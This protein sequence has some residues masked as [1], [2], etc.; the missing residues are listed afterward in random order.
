MQNQMDSPER[1]AAA[2]DQLRE[3]RYPDHAGLIECSYGDLPGFS[4]RNK[5]VYW[6]GHRATRLDD[7]ETWSKFLESEILDLQ[8]AI[9]N[10]S[11]ERS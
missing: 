8:T 1:I 2:V 7:V 6:M 10:C 4:R 3:H 11:A 9:E 5:W